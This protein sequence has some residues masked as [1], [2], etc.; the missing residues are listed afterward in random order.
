M[1][2]VEKVQKLAQLN[3]E[4]SAASDE[5]AK[6]IGQIGT[7]VTQMDKVTQANAASAEES[8]SASEELFAQAKELGDM[9]DVLAAMVKGGAAANPHS[10]RNSPVSTTSRSV[11]KSGGASA[12]SGKAPRDWTAAS[13]AGHNGNRGDGGLHAASDRSSAEAVLSL[14]VEDLRT[15]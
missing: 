4:V 5:Q 15:F 2:V 12:R 1:G 13:A 6:G 10:R 9:V 14:N 8:A 3:G 11:A 7:A